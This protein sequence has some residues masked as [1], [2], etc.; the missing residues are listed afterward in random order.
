MS[1]KTNPLMKLTPEDKEFFMTF[2]EAIIK[3]TMEQI[4]EHNFT[5]NINEIID[6]K[7]KNHCKQLHRTQCGNEPRE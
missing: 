3:Q 4:I 2:M 1:K 7:I 5:I 6:E